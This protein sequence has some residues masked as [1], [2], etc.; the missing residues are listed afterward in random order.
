MIDLCWI[1]PKVQLDINIQGPGCGD[2]AQRS[3]SCVNMLRLRSNDRRRYEH[4]L[5][6]SSEVRDGCMCYLKFYNNL[7]S[8]LTEYLL[9]TLRFGSL[10]S[11]IVGVISKL[12]QNASQMGIVIFIIL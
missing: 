3:L 7:P 8:A 10:C 12:T 1:A 11:S 5:L 2:E 9:L 4:V 6:L